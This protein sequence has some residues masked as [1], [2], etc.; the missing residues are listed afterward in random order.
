MIY[1]TLSEAQRNCGNRCSW[2]QSSIY[3]HTLSD[4]REYFAVIRFDTTD[5]VRKCKRCRKA[6]LRRGAVNLAK[7]DGDNVFTESAATGYTCDRCGNPFCSKVR[8]YRHSALN[9]GKLH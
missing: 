9:G 5:R 4:G 8:L 1:K 3:R 6:R 7:R 2:V